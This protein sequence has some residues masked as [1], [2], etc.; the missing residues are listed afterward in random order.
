MQRH[1]LEW[2]IWQQLEKFKLKN[3]KFLLLCSGGEDS[4][5][6]FY[7][8]NKVFQ[9]GAGRVQNTWAVLHLHHGD[10]ENKA[11][12][13]QA[14]KHVKNLCKTHQVQ[15]ITRK[16]GNVEIQSEQEFRRFRYQQAQ[17]IREE[18]GFDI[19][20]TAHHQQDLLETRLL[21]L[22]RGTGP[23]GLQAMSV[24][25]ASGV[26]RP[27]LEIPK[28]KITDYVFE[29]KLSYCQDPSNAQTQYL[30]NWLRHRWLPALE[31]KRP[32]S[33]AAMGRSIDVILQHV[34]SVSRSGTVSSS[35]LVDLAI[36]H[37]AEHQG[38]G[39]AMSRAF[40]LT[41]ST[42]E[43]L[44][45]L[46]QYLLL[47]IQRKEFTQ[48]HLKEIQK[49]LDNPQK[50]LTF[51]VAGCDWSINTQHIIAKVQKTTLV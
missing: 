10:H 8:L 15:F 32:G 9:G 2:T 49:R 34:D 18:Q 38:L 33:V 19:L 47:K 43:Q 27:W 20:I 44:R 37:Q 35:D 25:T 48:A 5:A 16:N 30:R 21:R 31:K 46:A 40:Y 29:K 17:Q 6:L 14:A 22:L 23:Q 4:V 26:W 3:K 13:N 51:K 24:L 41:L 45:L 1:H 50:E 28:S 11:H 39:V 12:R 42:T 7:A 36:D